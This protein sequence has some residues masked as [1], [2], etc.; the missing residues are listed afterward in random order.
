MELSTKENG[1]S[2]QRNVMGKGT[3]YGPMVLCMRG[4]GRMIRLMGEED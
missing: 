2:R 3:R 4:I 1:M